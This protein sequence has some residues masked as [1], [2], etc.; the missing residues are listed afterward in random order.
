MYKQHAGTFRTLD[1]GLSQ[2]AGRV[3]EADAIV[4]PFHGASMSGKR[5]I[6]TGTM[7]R[8]FGF[9]FSHLASRIVALLPPEL[10]TL[11][12]SAPR[13]TKS[14]IKAYVD[15]IRGALN[16]ENPHAFLEGEKARLRAKL[17]DGTRECVW[18]CS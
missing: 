4:R 11:H 5:R 16:S 3:P 1:G 7:R 14:A 6:Q 10:S 17:E 8:P 2:L 15:M 9:V 18:G 12:S 13:G